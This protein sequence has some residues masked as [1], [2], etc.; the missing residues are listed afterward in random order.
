MTNQKGNLRT[1]NA[2]SNFEF[3]LYK[4]IKNGYS[5][6]IMICGEQRIGKSAYALSLCNNFSNFMYE[7][8]FNFKKYSFYDTERVLVE[9]GD[10]VKR[11]I[12]ID[13]GGE[14]MDYL[15]WY[16]KIAKAMRS[17]INTQAFRGN[18]YVIINP[19]VVEILKNIRK[20]FNFKCY[21]ID[22][23]QVKIWK[24]IKKHHAEKQEKAS[25]PIFLDSITFKLSDIPKG[26]F[27][28]YKEF[29]ESEKEKIRI[30][31]MKETKYKKKRAKLSIEERIDNLM[32]DNNA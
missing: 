14:S 16:E 22:R 28:G 11:V 5:P 25:Y 6:I 23:G 18:V 17:M 8:D 9:M 12:L 20:H 21:V 10:M 24:Y 7:E 27:E 32:G 30:D 26:M 31:R 13:E 2:V 1:F 3:Q 29:S 4:K 15:D 19:F